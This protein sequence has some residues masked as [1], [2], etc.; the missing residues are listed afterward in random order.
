MFSSLNF[1]T[2]RIDYDSIGSNPSQSKHPFRPPQVTQSVAIVY[3]T[4]GLE[5]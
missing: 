5:R 2:N 4:D 3:T 1:L